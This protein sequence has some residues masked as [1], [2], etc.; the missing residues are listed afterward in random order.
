MKWF[1]QKENKEETMPYSPATVLEEDWGI[2]IVADDEYWV[3]PL[4]KSQLGSYARYIT[5]YGVDLSYGDK[6][7]NFIPASQ[8]KAIRYQSVKEYTEEWQK[9]QE[10]KQENPVGL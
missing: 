2:I 3:S 7:S 10:S 4:R 5:Q 1:W 8:I 6:P 9:N